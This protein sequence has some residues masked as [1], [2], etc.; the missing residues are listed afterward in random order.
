MGLVSQ[1][2][3]DPKLAEFLGELETQGGGPGLDAARDSADPAGG[4]PDR[5][6]PAPLKR[7]PRRFAKCCP[8]KE[9]EKQFHE[10]VKTLRE[11]AHIKIML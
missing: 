1:S 11:K 10:W 9:M 5:R 4:T 6:S 8:Q 2:D 7:W 3:L